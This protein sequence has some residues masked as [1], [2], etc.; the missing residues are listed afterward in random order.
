MTL[1]NGIYVREAVAFQ[2]TRWGWEKIG[3]GCREL[4]VKL[5]KS[6]KSH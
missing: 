1:S 2:E 5:D 6:L 3:I 4:P